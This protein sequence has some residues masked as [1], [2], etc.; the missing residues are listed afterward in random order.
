M[1]SFVCLF[2]Y[3]VEE[4]SETTNIHTNDG[5]GLPGWYDGVES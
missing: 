4:A 5:T 3:E 2:L 1:S